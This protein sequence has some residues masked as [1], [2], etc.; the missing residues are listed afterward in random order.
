LFFFFAREK[1]T[2]NLK[3]SGKFNFN[4]IIFKKREKIEKI[5]KLLSCFESVC[6]DENQKLR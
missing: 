6:T 4:E 1:D 2:K 5:T 3:Q